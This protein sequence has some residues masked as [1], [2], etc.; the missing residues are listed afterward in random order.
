M[1]SRPLHHARGRFRLAKG[2]ISS[3]RPEERGP[4]IAPFL[5]WLVLFYTAW[6]TLV[7][8]GDYWT[9]LLEHWGIAAAMAA[10]SYFAGATPMGGG[11]VGFP[12][13]VLLFGESGSLGR[14]FSFAI[15]SIGMVSASCLIL[16]RRQPLEGEILLSA[17]L[18]SLIGTPLG[19]LFVAPLVSELFI[20]VLFAVVWASFGIL[21][22]LRVEEL[23][24]LAGV[25]SRRRQLDRPLG[26]A[27]GLLGGATMASITGVGI[28]MLV[29][30][31]LVLLRRTDLKVAIPT[32]VVLMASTSVIGL[33]M[34]S[35]T[36]GLDQGVFENWLAAAPV[37]AIGA[38]I[39]AFVVDRIGRRITLYVVSLLCVTQYVWTIVNEGPRLGP[40]GIWLTCLAVVLFVL[41][42]EWLRAVGV[43]IAG[44]GEARAPGS[45]V[46]DSHRGVGLPAVG[47]QALH[48]PAVPRKGR[49]LEG[50]DPE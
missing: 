40:T 24:T 44:T 49:G 27:V 45:F 15:Q 20:K 2:V 25:P 33:T 47:F 1:T 26:F 46:T 48:A 32:S 3:Q 38:P 21:H 19:I 6:L 37:V 50:T 22:F 18:G 36:S 35:L 23:A 17:I 43:R 34:K 42:F 31:V 10:G 4:S 8:I 30:T 9:T 28:D 39:G 5:V 13:L 14:D 16:C 11:T 41:A 12:V 7:V 29:Y